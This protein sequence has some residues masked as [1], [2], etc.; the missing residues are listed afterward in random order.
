MERFI[1]STDTFKELMLWYFGTVV[2]CALLF[3]FFEHK[4]IDD[5]LWWAFVTALT[6]GYGDIYPVT[7]GGRIVAV[8]LMH[9]VVLIVAPIIIGRLLN[10]IMTD[11]HQFT[12]DEQEQI[13]KD[14]LEIKA[15]LAHEHETIKSSRSRPA[16]AAGEASTEREIPAFMP[17]CGGSDARGDRDRDRR[18]CAR[19]GGH[20]RGPPDR[21]Y[22]G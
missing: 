6:V 19:P 11:A 2:S 5:A 8:L 16:I 17:S 13:K 1:K 20:G 9:S 3:S 14:L 12:N 22:S 21:P 15:L 18:C 10:K 4:P 7:P